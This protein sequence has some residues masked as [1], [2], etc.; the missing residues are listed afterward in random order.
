M[1][2]YST[3][4]LRALA[5]DIQS[6]FP[7]TDRGQ[8]RVRWFLLTLKAI[9]VPITASRTSNLLRAIETLFGVSIAEWRYY[10]FMASVKLPWERLWARLWCAIPD[11]LT[12]GRLLLALDDS[13]N[14]KTGKKVFACQ[15]TFD[16]AA[17]INQTRYPWAQTVVTVGLLKLIHGRWSCLPLAFAF[18]L[19]RKTL[20]SGCIRV[21]GKAVIFRSKFEQA[22]TLIERLVG[23]FTEAPVVVVADSWFGNNGLLKPLRA[24]LGERVQLL[25]RLRVNAVLYAIAELVEGRR[26]RPRKYGERLGNAAD[27][28]STMRPEAITYRVHIY[29]RERE[30]VAAERI[31]ML[32]T[33]R[34]RVRV[35]WV[36][37]NTQWIALMT[38][39]L[40]LSVK[41]VIEF[42]AARWK[43]KAGFRET[44]QE[45]GSAHT[46]TRNPDAVTNHLH[47]CMA[48]TTITWIYA[49]HLPQAPIRRY[50]SKRTTEYAFADARRALAKHIANEGFDIDCPHSRKPDRNPLISTVM[51][52]VA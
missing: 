2:P 18:Y 24:R 27:L 14:P 44:K 48:A 45:I 5:N 47:F 25:S 11:P 41:Q 52:L 15:T 16:H 1:N 26:G 13:I 32:K 50:A 40:T 30:V 38:T 49:T 6:L 4:I 23:T 33:L 42:Y 9:I 20:R 28:A 10:T 36:Y 29:G 39:D 17:K 43:I 7:N 12:D 34:C 46:Q 31:V 3:P 51:R 22:V 37:R 35:V 8:E 19:R 21:R